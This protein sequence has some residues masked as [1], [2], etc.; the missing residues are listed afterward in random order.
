MRHQILEL[1]KNIFVR[2]LIG[3]RQCGENTSIVE[4]VMEQAYPAIKIRRDKA[5]NMLG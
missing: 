1:E 5:I 3:I 4:I 2:S